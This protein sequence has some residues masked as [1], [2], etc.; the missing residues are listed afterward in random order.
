MMESNQ[1]K[2]RASHQALGQN[3]KNNKDR[4]F[5]HNRDFLELYKSCPLPDGQIIKNMGLFAKRQSLSRVLYMYELYKKIINVH[6]I[7]VEFGVRWG[8]NLALFQNFRA[9]F[10]PYN[11]NRK[12]VG[13]DTFAGFP[14][15]TDK[16]HAHKHSTGDMHVVDEYEIYLE[17]ILQAHEDNSPVANVK[18]FEICKGDAT[19]TFKEYLEKNPET[20]IALA[21][22]DFD[23]YEPTKACLELCRDRMTKGSII[24]F[25]ELNHP[26]WPGETRA[27]QD[28]LGLKNIRLQR[29]P[30][31]PTTSF[32]E[33][34]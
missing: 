2:S 34:E 24:A 31:N 16:D 6:G 10:E 23:L 8:Q 21:Y 17:K 28:V 3:Q 29:M 20:I 30:F 9:M 5:N 14:T 1:K 25:D 13:F 19:V 27:V 15:V 11:H 18:K 33:I 12:I 26:N 32:I 7:I 4:E 22:F